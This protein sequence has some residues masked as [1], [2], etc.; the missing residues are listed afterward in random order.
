MIE[1][2]A[3]PLVSIITPAY[4]AMPYLKTTIESVLNQEYSNLEHIIF[5]GGSTD[6][7]VKVLESYSHLTW[8]SEKDRGQAHALNKGFA[9][10]KGEIIGWL[11][12][13][14]TYTSET[15]KKAVNFLMNHPEFDM[16]GT[17]A[18]IIDENDFVSGKAIGGETDALDL[19]RRNVIKQ[20]SL[21]MRRTVIDKLKG[22]NEDFHYIMDQEFWVR[23]FM[24]GFTYKYLPGECY[25]N[26]RL[27]KGTK[28]F[29]SGP[30]F[31]EE[32]HNYTL[33]IINQ[34]FYNFLS[35]SQKNTIL[36]YS[37]MKLNFSKMQL[38]FSQDEKL[39]AIKHY[40]NTI[41]SQPSIVLNLSLTKL[42]VLGLFNK[43]HNM[44]TK[45]KKNASKQENL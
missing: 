2:K 22:V 15:I 14:D 33:E 38:A 26:F 21:F 30:A 3:F 8:F 41:W 9:L 25:A 35:F 36:A 18:N 39:R 23:A 5:D 40:F 6:D 7:S 10:A 27:I 42:L 31:N 12:A 19:L 34:P 24:N 1:N 11:N 44:L 13:D 37:F 17:D 45:F 28:T 32:W 20:P 16:V 4:N 43:K 29:D